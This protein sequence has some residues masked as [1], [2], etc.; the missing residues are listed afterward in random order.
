M[1]TRRFRQKKWY[2][3]RKQ[4]YATNSGR[5]CVQAW[6]LACCLNFSPLCQPACECAVSSLQ[7]TNR[8]KRE[9]LKLSLHL[10]TTLK[11]LL[12]AP[13]TSV[14]WTFHKSIVLLDSVATVPRFNLPL[15]TLASQTNKELA[16]D[17]FPCFLLTCCKEQGPGPRLAVMVRIAHWRHR[18]PPGSRPACSQPIPTRQA[19]M[20]N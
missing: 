15:R 1:E 6:D 16:A 2:V 11:F 13:S 14:T 20:C 7:I 18:T 5:D 19:E 3:D 9:A 12:M 8:I 10:Q 17:W 4:C